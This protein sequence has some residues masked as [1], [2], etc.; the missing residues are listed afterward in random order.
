M[1]WRNLW[2]TPAGK[3][4]MRSS[5]FP[6]TITIPNF[7]S[8]SQTVGEFWKRYH[9]NGKM[10]WK[11][12]LLWWLKKFLMLKEKFSCHKHY[13]PWRTSYE[14]CLKCG[15][16]RHFQGFWPA[17]WSPVAETLYSDQIELNHYFKLDRIW[18]NIKNSI[19]KCKNTIVSLLSHQRIPSFSTLQNMSSGVS[20]T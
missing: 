12:D 10:R 14:F 7:R 3:T 16:L 19:E 8:I 17:W 11:A 18:K 15:F 6:S 13:T 4:C 5:T 2:T 9:Q 20:W 1:D